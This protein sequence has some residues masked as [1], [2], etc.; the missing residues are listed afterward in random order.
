MKLSDRTDWRVPE[1]RADTIP[2]TFRGVPLS[3]P[4]SHWR[5]RGATDTTFG[6]AFDAAVSLSKPPTCLYHQTEE[7]DFGCTGSDAVAAAERVGASMQLA[8]A[9][10]CYCRRLCSAV[11]CF[12]VL[13]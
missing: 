13:L 9:V 12:A 11:L 10:Q 3:D 7:C 2:P 6:S 4:F 8:S 5:P 1:L